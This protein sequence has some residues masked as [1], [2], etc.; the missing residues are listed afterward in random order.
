VSEQKEEIAAGMVHEM[1]AGTLYLLG[2]GTTV[3]AVPDALGI[4]KT[5][6][7][8][9]AVVDG[10]RVGTDLN[11]REI[12]ELLDTYPD[13]EIVVTP[14]GG[15]GFV[16]GRGNKQFTPAVLRRVG[17]QHLIVVATPEKMAGLD[18][19]RVDTGDP[20]VDAALS[21]YREVVVGY[22]RARM[23]KVVA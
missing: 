11:E 1:R 17:A 4:E 5:L 18:V 21:G 13:R 23:V 2:P 22:R 7:G 14:I 6:L 19:L 8:I 20:A 3:R 16:L 12:L 15:N 10:E 9:D